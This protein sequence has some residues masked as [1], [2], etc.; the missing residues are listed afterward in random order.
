MRNLFGLPLTFVLWIASCFAQTIPTCKSDTAVTIDNREGVTVKT[1]SFQGDFGRLRA[2]VFIPDTDEP[3]PGVAFSQS[4]I[5]YSDSLTDL[6]PF[7][8]ALALAGAASIMLDGTIDWHRPNDDSK[9][10]MTELACASQWLAA[11]AN[12]DLRRLAIGGPIKIDGPIRIGDTPFCHAPDKQPCGDV[13][14]YINFGWNSPPEI[15]YTEMMKTPQ[16]QLRFIRS[17]NF[18]ESY[19]LKEIKLEWLLEGYCRSKWRRSEQP[20]NRHRL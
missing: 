20:F 19:N 12:L 16:G 14:W 4:A 13:G 5:Q 7:A 15:H 11:N 1:V 10:P 3:V 17:A 9:R 6:R 2:Y 18:L 8:R